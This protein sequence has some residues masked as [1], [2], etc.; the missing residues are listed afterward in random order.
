MIVYWQR[1]FRLQHMKKHGKNICSSKRFMS[2]IKRMFLDNSAQ[3]HWKIPYIL[4]QLHVY[5]GKCVT[6]VQKHDN[7]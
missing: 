7:A 5:L 6:D 1:V 4:L 3:Y 2:I